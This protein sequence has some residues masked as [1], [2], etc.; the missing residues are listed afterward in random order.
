MVKGS[1]IHYSFVIIQ[2]LKLH[3]KNT[4]HSLENIGALLKTCGMT[5]MLWNLLW[6]KIFFQFAKS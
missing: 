1:E 4:G 6:N 3:S 2:Y 5:I